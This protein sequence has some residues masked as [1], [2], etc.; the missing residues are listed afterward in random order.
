MKI[1]EY[2]AVTELDDDNV[3][4]LDG[5]TGTKKIAKSDLTYALFDSIPE[6]HN[7]LYRG[8]NLGSS[9]TSGQKEE[10]S[11]GTFHDLWIGDY[12][13]ISGS[14]W[15]ICGF[16]CAGSVKY[17]ENHLVIMGDAKASNIKWDSTTS[18]TD[19]GKIAFANSTIYTVD[20]PAYISN[21]IPS[22]F[23][24]NFYDREEQ[25]VSAKDSSNFSVANVTEVVVHANIPRISNIFGMS[26]SSAWIKKD[27]VSWNSGTDISLHNAGGKFPIFEF[28]KAYEI[29]GD[30]WFWL[31]DDNGPLA[32]R[33]DITNGS[34]VGYNNKDITAYMIPYFVISG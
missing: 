15:Y 31:Q 24:S 32:A 11:N 5:T 19:M 21:T 18:G 26:N 23:K 3:F 7:H 9:Y 29:F 12:W 17:N 33:Y 2:P 22:T 14:K 13:S 10:V 27:G 16:N 1:T 30:G 6:M 25:I 28:V 4:L 8:K 20:L 34:G